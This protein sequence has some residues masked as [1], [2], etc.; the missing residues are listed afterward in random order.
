MET[1]MAPYGK[2]IPTPS[3]MGVRGA[4]CFL[5]HHRQFPGGRA[6]V[7]VV[8]DT[9]EGKETARDR[10]AAFD[11]GSWVLEQKGEKLAHGSSG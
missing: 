8:I 3:V 11:D 10:N 6:D 7:F 9:Q 4:L 5:I 2:P 1:S